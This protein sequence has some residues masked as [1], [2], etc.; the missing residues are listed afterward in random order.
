MSTFFFS[1]ACTLARLPQR[2]RTLRRRVLFIGL[3]SKKKGRR[4]IHPA[5]LG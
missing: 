5:A 1:S 3:F 2:A 4:D